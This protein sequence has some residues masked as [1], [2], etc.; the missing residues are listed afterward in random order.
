MLIRLY[1]YQDNFNNQNSNSVE[2]MIIIFNK[3]IEFFMNFQM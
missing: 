2:I 1:S 3:I